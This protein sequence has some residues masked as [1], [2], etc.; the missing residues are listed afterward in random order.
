MPGYNPNSIW[1]SKEKKYTYIP[2]GNPTSY[3]N[4]PP[5]TQ[6]EPPAGPPVEPPKFTNN[7]LGRP[8][9][10]RR[11]GL[12]FFT[13]GIFLA[14]GIAALIYYLLLPPSAPDIV[15]AF[16]DPGTVTAGE[17]FSVTVTVSNESKSVIEN[18]QVN[19]MLPSSSL[20][21]ASG[22][23]P[24]QEIGT[25]SSGTVNPP[26]IFWLVATG[27]AGTLGTT[28]IVNT[29]FT[30][31]TKETAATEFTS[32]AATSFPIGSQPALSLSYN[33]PS[34]IFSG[35]N[36]PIA[37]N[38]EN[39]T[40]QTLQGIQ[41][42]MKYPPAFHFSS[43]STTAPIDAGDD[44][45]NLGSLAPEASGTII[46]TGNI[47]GPAQVQYQLNGTIGATFGGQ[48]YPAYT[49]PVTFAVTPSPL[50]LTIALNNSSTYVAKPA[51]TLNYVLTYTN[52]SNVAFESVNISAALT[53]QMYDFRSLQTNGAF[54][55]QSDVISWN[56]AN[57]PQ[58]SSLAPGQS[59]SVNFTIDT[60]SAFPPT[61]VREG[62]K[63]YTVAVAAQAQSPT[64]PPNTAGANTT[65]A[66]TL[67]SKVGGEIALTANGYTKETA[68]KIENIGPYP[69]K[70]N[71]PT[72]YTIHWN[73]A[74]YST[75]AQN[76]TVSAYLQ[77]GTTFTGMATSTVA[78]STF[79]YSAGT[80][81][82][83]WTIPFIPATAG[84][85]GAPIQEVFQVSDT[86]AINQVGQAVTLVGPTTLNATD[87]WT[88]SAVSA[89]AAPVTTRLP[90]DPSATGQTGAVTQ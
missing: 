27:A 70:V 47:V 77:S 49:A 66:T 73:L 88:N 33:A 89:T 19:L 25:L 6:A 42:Q 23:A 28:Q 36:F 29:T 38:Y 84:V 74:N 50:L 14:I 81:L 5:G 46:I 56:A 16:S 39:N 12:A 83:T 10:F 15:I 37:V 80:G 65:S 41:L 51:D 34:S 30:Y 60:L 20:A 52:N 40:T 7:Q 8:S 68:T 35:Q 62:Y 2:P 31:Q 85:I 71:Q 44:T 3:T 86:P 55:S 75:D 24:T 82:I 76:I 45:W 79:S 69:P 54:N 58:L 61:L 78:S 11:H 43:S 1:G 53:G 17:P 22:T 18:G 13:I 59:G 67:T 90:N 63:N 72:E 21:F 64:V 32:S 26:E 87:E 57:T 48:N 4:V 9:F